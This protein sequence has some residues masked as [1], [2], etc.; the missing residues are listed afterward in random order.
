L[1]RRAGAA[2]TLIEVLVTLLV[3]AMLAGVAAVT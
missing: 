3:V 2:V 1:R